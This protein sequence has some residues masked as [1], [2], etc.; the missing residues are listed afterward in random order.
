MEPQE[1]LKTA[2]WPFEWNMTYKQCFDSS[3]IVLKMSLLSTNK[4]HITTLGFVL[5]PKQLELKW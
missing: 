5:L 3:P 2:T 4:T 1:S